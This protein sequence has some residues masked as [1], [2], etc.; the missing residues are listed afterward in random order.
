MWFDFAEC[1]AGNRLPN[2]DIVTAYHV[3]GDETY[4]VLNGRKQ[5]LVAVMTRAGEGIVTVSAQKYR[6]KAGTVILLDGNDIISYRTADK[7]W[8]FWW[9]EF[10]SDLPRRA[11]LGTPFRTGTVPGEEE[12]FRMILDDLKQNNPEAKSRACYRFGTVLLSWY[13]FSAGTEQRNGKTPYSE[14]I[15]RITEEMS[16]LPL[17][18]LDTAALAKRAGLGPCR[19]V[20]V[21]K[22]E[23]GMTPKA[24]YDRSRFDLACRF[25]RTSR[26]GL[27]IIADRLHFS[28]AYHF[29][30][31]F[32]KYAGV[33][34]RDF[35]RG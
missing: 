27:D 15:R 12:N 22:L 29:S 3:K 2:V 4:S 5:G 1:A 35:R 30:R 11:G 9:F 18:I 13:L 28:S 25:L 24:Y 17:E 6:L 8:H 20:Q 10:F 26:M 32:K 16:R 14:I 7:K 34:P 31:F 33:P 19:F 23:T 21:F